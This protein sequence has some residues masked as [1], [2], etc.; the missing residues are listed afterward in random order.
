MKSQ[1]N[2][3]MRYDLTRI[4]KLI[5]DETMLNIAMYVDF[6]INGTS[7]ELISYMHL[8]WYEKIYNLYSDMIQLVLANALGLNLIILSKY[9][10]DYDT[11]RICCGVLNEIND[12]L[13][14]H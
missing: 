5:Y 8:Y 2:C 13:L 1:T 9:T 6:L 12:C 7:D 14:V 11:R 10:A 3:L 4:I